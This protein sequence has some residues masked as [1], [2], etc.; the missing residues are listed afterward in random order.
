MAAVLSNLALSFEQD[1]RPQLVTGDLTAR[2]SEA[3]AVDMT[4]S[5]QWLDLDRI[6]GAGERAS[7]LESI[8]PLAVRLHDLLPAE[9][10]SRASFSVTQAN[11]GG[12]AISG[13]QLVL[14]RTGDK[15]EVQDLRLGM[16]GGSRGEL[17]GVVTGPPEAPAFAG[18][19]ALRG[20]SLVRFL[21]WVTGNALPSDPKSDGAFGVRSQL[22]ISHDRVA[23]R[24]LIGDLSG[25]AI[26]G[27]ANYAWGA[28]PELSL[29]VESPQL[30]ARAFIPAG[31]GL[32]EAFQHLVH[33][34][35]EGQQASSSA[36][37]RLEF[38]PDGPVH[39]RQRRSAD[40]G[41]AHLSG[42]GR[43]S[44]RQGRQPAAAAAARGQRPG[45]QPGAR[46]QDR[47][48]HLAAQGHAAGHR[49]RRHGPRRRAAG[50]AARH[51]RA[52]PPGRPARGGRSC[53]CGSPAPSSFGVRTPTSTDMVLDGEASGAT[54]SRSTGASTAAP[55]AGGRAPPI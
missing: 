3:L 33:G 22:L 36:K 23:A 29:S 17:K 25:T 44:G 47:Q 50:G 42:R 38:G 16:P 41:S 1:G 4:L 21:A 34:A 18:N 5:S 48:R 32:A 45:L 40:H 15:L 2:W 11:I 26:Y 9:S 10:R 28:R 51:L 8:V 53:R 35:A 37:S 55:T 7:P 54:A 27:T 49:H 19:I 52:L 20:V 30:D 46:R 6:A 24:D 14:A 43:A 39:S 31:A 13:L 12:E